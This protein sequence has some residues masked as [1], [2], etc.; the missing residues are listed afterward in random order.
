VIFSQKPNHV[1]EHVANDI[2]A[3]AEI[4]RI[5]K[6]GGHA[7]LQTPFS[8]LLHTTW[9]D[10]G[11]SNDVARLIAYGQNDHVRLYGKDIF[12]RISN[13]GLTPKIQ[14]HKTALP[15]FTPNIYGVNV[16]EPFFLFKRD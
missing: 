2:K 3:L 14:R 4:Y 15:Q 5:L 11:I 10:D 7:I 8:S 12:E 13:S 16:N 6:P 1:L 9:S